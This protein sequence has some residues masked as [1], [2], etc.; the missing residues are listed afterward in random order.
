MSEDNYLAIRKEKDNKFR[1]YDLSASCDHS[2]KACKHSVF[3][4]DTVEEAVKKAQD[5]CWNNMVEYG[6]NFINL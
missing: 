3:E 5:Y 4:A 6:F 1:A 2:D